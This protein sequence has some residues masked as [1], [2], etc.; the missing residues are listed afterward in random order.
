MHYLRNSYRFYECY[1]RQEY[2]VPNTE[3]VRMVI[4]FCRRLLT[5]TIEILSKLGKEVSPTVM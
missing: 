5:D 3:L 2:G 1:I 4:S